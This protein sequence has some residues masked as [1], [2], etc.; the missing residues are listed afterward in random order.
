MKWPR[1]CA[2]LCALLARAALGTDAL[3]ENDGTVDYTGTPG[4]YPPVIDA[5]NFVNDNGGIFI[6]DWNIIPNLAN[7]YYET[8]NTINYTNYNL[9]ASDDGF[10]FDTQTTAGSHLMA[11]SFYN[12]GQVDCGYQFLARAT[13]IVNPGTV[14]VQGYNVIVNSG[15][16]ATGLAGLLQFTGQNVDLSRSALTIANG[17]GTAQAVGLLGLTGADTNSDWDATFDLGPTFAFPSFPV[18]ALPP[19]PF[20]FGFPNLPL[21]TTPYFNFASPVSNILIIR[22]V[23]I[24]DA[25][26]N[27]AHNVYFD[28]AGIVG[29]GNATVEWLGG[30]VDPATGS[31][32]TNYLYLNDNYLESVA[33]NDL[34]LG[35]GI[36]ENFTFAESPTPIFLGT[37]TTPGFFNV[38]SPGF[39]TNRFAYVSAQLIATSAGTNS[40][41]NGAI[42]NLPSRIQINASRELNLALAQITQPDY[43]SLQSSNQFDGNAGARIAAPFS[44]L[45]L[46][47]T[48]GNLTITNLLPQSFPIW[49]GT[50]QAW[51]TRW[52]ILSSNISITIGTNGVATTNSYTVTNDFRVELV[53]SQITPTLAG[54]VQDLTLHGTNSVI[55]SDAFNVMRNLFI[56]AQNLTLT[57]N[58]P[59]YGA[60]SADGELNLESPNIFWASSLPNLRWLTNNGAISTMNLAYFGSSALPY[61]AFVNR[62]RVSNLGGSTI[63]AQDFENYGTFYS[64]V[65]SFNLQ[66]LT[67]MMTNSSV[68]AGANVA[69]GADSLVASNL[70]LFAGA[71]LNLTVTNLLTDTSVT[72]G[73]NWSIGSMAPSASPGSYFIN[74]FNLP[75]KPPTGDLLGTIVSNTAPAQYV[76][77]GLTNHS[78]AINNLWA[79][80]DYGVSNSGY[81]N[82]VAVG[83][84]VLDAQGANSVFR[85]YGTGASNALYVDELELLDYASY[86]N[87]DLGGNLPALIFNTNLVLYYAQ[88]IVAGGTSVAEKLNHKNNDHLRWVPTYAGHFSGTNIVYPDGTTNGPF[89]TA[90]AQSTDIDSDGDGVVNG[91]DPTPFFVPSEVNFTLTLT[92]LP[93]PSV[94][95]Q[96]TT[97]PLATNYIYFKT[98]LLSSNWLPLTNFDN[99]Y[100]GANVAVT[101]PAHANGF[102]SPQPYPSATTNVWVFDVV[103][104]VPH[105]YR[106]T[107]TPWLTYPY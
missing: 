55:L 63:W 53:A 85:F 48:N 22:A 97:I 90:L 50:V 37:P 86:T 29:G 2:L 8:W 25:S 59:G 61:G 34:S 77:S 15:T 12:P 62:G 72:N 42:T 67:T 100:Y 39:V 43:L 49:G 36:P 47:V 87:H 35:N 45:N 18:S 104:N 46:G 14:N 83:L 58:T 70:V 24:Q 5:T 20:G 17:Q 28:T 10:W 66:S 30:Y 6:I 80:R 23:F 98:N 103:T 88:A 93:P 82:N 11:G 41:P 89:N 44:D 102:I 52:F 75:L 78:V 71:A 7:T 16:G 56:D 40:I 38:F 105:Y 32:A 27:V 79:G 96:W 69:I 101:N 54:Q 91:S 26:P 21:N 99:Y 68:V 33:T 107:V 73:N 106:V 9:M 64:G 51:S 3:Y 95:L 19:P 74:G 65:G 81:T 31:P 4:T 1:L 92:N 76:I 57:T 84:L 94:Q 60:T 13:N